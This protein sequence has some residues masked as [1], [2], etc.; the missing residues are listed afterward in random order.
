MGVNVFHRIKFESFPRLK[1]VWMYPTE[2][3]SNF[4]LQIRVNVFL[5]MSLNLIFSE[6]CM[7]M[8]QFL[9]MTN[10]FESFPRNK[11]ECGI[12]IFS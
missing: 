12:W 7:W 11:G 6:K 10:E 3:S 1:W 5:E 8:Y 2:M 4:F 9:E